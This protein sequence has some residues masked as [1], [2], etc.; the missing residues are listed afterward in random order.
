MITKGDLLLNCSKGYNP[1]FTTKKK[2]RKN[3][4]VKLLLF[5][6]LF[7]YLFFYQLMEFYIYFVKGILHFLLSLLGK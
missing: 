4:R 2:K 3:R 6:Y 7:P 5:M 1:T